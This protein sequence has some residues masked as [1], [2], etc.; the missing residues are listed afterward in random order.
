MKEQIHEE[1]KVMAAAERQM[2]AWVKAGEIADRAVRS[3][4]KVGPEAKIGPFITISREEGAGGGQIG[5]LLSE[6]LGW[7]VLD[8]NL[9]DRVADRFKIP[10]AVLEMVDETKG[11]WVCDILE[12]GL[13]PGRISHE[14]YVVHLSRVIMTAARGGKVVFV[15]RG[16]RFLL[17]RR[18]GLAVRVIAPENYRIEQIMELHGVKASEAQR[19]IRKADRQRRRFVRDF[20]HHDVD[21]PHLYDMVI[22]SER[23][24]PVA[25]ADAIIAIG[26]ALGFI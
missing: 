2:Q 22:N 20:F 14:K 23:A 5:R 9:V 7:D 21:D 16:A 18:W 24:G 4:E 19:I 15:G 12:P 25:T 1:P 10:R 17:P 13:D 6:K 26:S 11:D 3:G 8:K